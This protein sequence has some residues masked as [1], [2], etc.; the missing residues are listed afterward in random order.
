M[1]KWT[2]DMDDLIVFIKEEI[3]APYSFCLE[4]LR[5]EYPSHA[6]TR[7]AIISHHRYMIKKRAIPNKPRPS[8]K[9][10]TIRQVEAEAMRY[11]ILG[12]SGSGEIK[13]NDPTHSVQSYLP[14]ADARFMV[15]EKEARA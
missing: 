8:T 15:R 14:F 7:N 12:V 3:E 2:K 6:F 10:D 4:N 5:R 1:V 9:N 13:W 11:A